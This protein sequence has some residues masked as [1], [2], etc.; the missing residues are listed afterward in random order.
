M[1]ELDQI[2]HREAIREA[3]LDYLSKGLSVIPCGRN[4]KPLIKWDEFNDRIA[5]PEEFMDWFGKFEDMQLALV[6]GRVSGITA[7]DIETGGVDQY[8]DIPTSCPIYRTGKGGK[9]YW[10]LY[11]PRAKTGVRLREFLDI[12]NDRSYVIVPP[13]KSEYGDYTWIQKVPPMT[14]PALLLANN[15]GNY[16][17]PTINLNPGGLPE[18][19]GCT[20]G[21]RNDSMTKYAGQILPLIHPLDWDTIGWNQFQLANLQNQ[22]PLPEHELRRTWDS[23]KSKEKANPSIRA[24]QKKDESVLER[25]MEDVDDSIVTMEEAANEEEINLG[26]PIPTGLQT[27]DE[28]LIGGIRPGDLVVISGQSGEGKSTIAQSIT[29]NITELGIP[30][31]FFTYEVLVSEMWEKFQD[32]QVKA[33]GLI[34]TPKKH[35]NNKVTWVHEKIKEAKKYGC[36]VVVIDH[37]EFLTSEMK[38]KN[39]N[40]NYSNKVSDI[41]KAVKNMALV[42]E[43]PIILLFHLRKINQ[44]RPTLNDAKDSI[45]IIQLADVGMIIERNRNPSGVAGSEFYLPTSTLS[46]QKNRRKGGKTCYVNI[47]MLQGRLV[48][49]N[50]TP[51]GDAEVKESPAIKTS[52][53]VICEEVKKESEQQSL[54]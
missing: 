11:E 37:L 19:A 15:T 32:M 18:Y 40:Q 48:E 26:D 35:S 44:G 24:F 33:P 45:S 31:V 8:T 41:I 52:L 1:N 3:G 10:C 14:Y 36:K 38:D 43:I 51:T 39:V 34:F 7:I 21:G 30:V 54:M 42:E 6:M 28:C 16:T 46:L 2:L 5:T 47:G 12:R 49:V 53:D 9:H 17:K 20:E 23:I 50:Y 25:K 13:S 22:P 4:K 29:A 27:I